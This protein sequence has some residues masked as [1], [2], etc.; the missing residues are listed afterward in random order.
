MMRIISI[1]AAA[2]ALAGCGGMQY[3]ASSGGDEMR[4]RAMGLFVNE[5]SVT[6]SV[7]GDDGDNTD[8]R[9]VDVGDPGR[10]TI[11]ISVDSPER[12]EGGVVSLHDEFGGQIERRL[13]VPNQPS[14]T[15]ATEVENT[16]TKYFVKM[17]TPTGTS[18]YSL[19]ARQSYRPSPRPPVVARVEPEPPPVVVKPVR[20]KPVRRPKRRR[21]VVKPVVKR[22]PPPPPPPVAAGVKG[23]VTRVI[24]AKNNKSCTLSLRLRGGTVPKGARGD[25]LQSGSRIGSIKVIQ[26]GGRSVTAVV[27]LPPGKVTGDLTV[28]FR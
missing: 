5:G 10:L 22:A 13:L 7:D 16:P 28:R 4:D 24:P 25:L 27:N 2:I 18:V 14:Y 8:W 1:G 6:D 23:F 9:Y 17:F 12:L 15:F 20:R 11:S 19:G 21:P 26:V 3:D